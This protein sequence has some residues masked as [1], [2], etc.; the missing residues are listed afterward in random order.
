[1]DFYRILGAPMDINV[2][3]IGFHWRWNLSP[4]LIK[5]GNGPVQG[6]APVSDSSPIS[7]WFMV[8]I[9]TYYSYGLSTNVHI[10]GG[11]HLLGIPLDPVVD[12]G[13]GFGF[14]SDVSGRHMRKMSGIH[15]YV[16]YMNGIDEWNYKIIVYKFIDSLSLVVPCLVYVWYI[17]I[18]YM[19]YIYICTNDVPMMYQLCTYSLGNFG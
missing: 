4:K 15:L 14:S 18:I 19:S 1:M 8:G 11:H 16:I 3:S 10:T 2:G 17:F 12:R 6:A 7:L 5:T 13:F 9:L